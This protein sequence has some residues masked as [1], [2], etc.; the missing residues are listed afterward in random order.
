M[1]SPCDV[2]VSNALRNPDSGEIKI[3]VVLRPAPAPGSKVFFAAAAPPDRRSSFTGSGLPFA[4]E[5]QAFEATPNRGETGAVDGAEVSFVLAAPPNAY[6]VG[7]GTLLVPPSVQVRYVD[8]AGVARHGAASVAD[9]AGIA[10]RTNTYQ[11]ARATATFYEAP[12]FEARSQPAI[13]AASAYPQSAAL[14]AQRSAD[15]DFWHGKPPC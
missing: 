1:S 14:A 10:Y 11:R 15:M 12:Y 4:N 6:Y 5:R 13:L 8:V 2:S 3:D 7:L 9:V